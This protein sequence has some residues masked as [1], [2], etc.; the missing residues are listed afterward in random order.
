MLLVPNDRVM[1]SVHNNRAVVIKYCPL[2]SAKTQSLWNLVYSFLSS[3]R[4]LALCKD[5]AVFYKFQHDLISE[6]FVDESDIVSFE[7]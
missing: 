5:A 6:L 2:E 3:L 7:A 4:V 1:E